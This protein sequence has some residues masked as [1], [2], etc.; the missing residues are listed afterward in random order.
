MGG[1]FHEDGDSN[2]GA[3]PFLKHVSAL[4]ASALAG[5]SRVP[6]QVVDEDLG[7]LLLQRQAHAVRRVSVHEG[8]VGDEGDD[9]SFPDSV[10]C[11]AQGTEVGV[12]EAVLV[13][14]G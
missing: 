13:C 14:S 1:I 6:L 2:A 11:P 8:A 5:C 12:V 7:E 9:A 3:R 10:R 4:T